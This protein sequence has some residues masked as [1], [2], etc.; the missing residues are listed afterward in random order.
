MQSAVFLKGGRRDFV[1]YSVFVKKL[2]II[3]ICT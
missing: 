2:Y 3:Q 1:H